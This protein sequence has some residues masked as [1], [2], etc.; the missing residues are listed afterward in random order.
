[1]KVFEFIS[2]MIKELLIAIP[3]TICFYI[4]FKESIKLSKRKFLITAIAFLVCIVLF[5]ALA[6]YVKSFGF[7]WTRHVFYAIY[8]LVNFFFCYSTLRLKLSQLLYAL[9]V[10][11]TYLYCVCCT[12]NHLEARYFPEYF[13]AE[14]GFYFNFIH[15][16]LLGTTAPFVLIFFRKLVKPVVINSVSPIWK[17]MWIIPF[18]FIVII[19]IYTG[20]YDVDR[21]AN[22]QYMTV[23][24][25]FTMT[26]FSIYYIVIKMALQ[27]EENAVLM[28]GI[29]QSKIAV[30][31]SQ[32]QPHF[33]YNSLV[34]VRQLCKTDPKLAEETVVE[35]SDYLRG[36][37]E[38]LTLIKPIPFERELH[39]VEIYLAIEKKRFGDKLNVV[40]DIKTMDFTL[41][42]LTLQPIVENAVR[43][44]VTKSEDGGTV[45]VTVEDVENSTVITVEDDGTGFDTG[46]LSGNEG[47]ALSS[48]KGAGIGITN[49]RSRLASMCGGTLNII[50]KPGT[51]TTAV[52]TIPKGRE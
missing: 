17:H 21:L 38:S 24:L 31:L 48:T 34:V 13:V 2:N 28:Q 40:Y 42:S 20:T 41:P 29:E 26:S 47:V 22:W 44:G 19:S 33:L 1:M 43:Y 35:F 36:N 3:T 11:A 6:A 12:V 39:H 9:F 7:R 16:L 51:G 15:A 8:L 5:T 49:V 10:A 52:I 37:L 18:L 30:M 14:I 27:A 46:I 25:M 23:I 4:P 50:S 45:K 32:I